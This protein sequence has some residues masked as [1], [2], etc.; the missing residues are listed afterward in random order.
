MNISRFSPLQ[1]LHMKKIIALM[2]VIIIAGCYPASHIVVGDVRPPVSPHQVK[3][4]L[5]YPEEYEKIALVDAGSNFAFKDPAILFTWQSKSNKVIER[6]KITA[7]ELG[8]NGIVI[9]STDNKIHQSMNVDKEGSVS[10][11]P[12]MEKYGQA[13]AIYVGP[14]R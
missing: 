12:Y 11:N 7:S 6:L 10:S 2:I 5:D 13:V 8:A 3:L 9:V 1:P 4:Y 14:N